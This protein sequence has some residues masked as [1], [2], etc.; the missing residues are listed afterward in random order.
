MQFGTAIIDPPWCYSNASKSPKLSGFANHEYPLLNEKGLTLLPVGELVTDTIFLWTTAP[1]VPQALR[2]IEAWGF[3]YITQLFW[4]KFSSAPDGRLI[5]QTP[6]G[7]NVDAFPHKPNY[8]VGYWVR[9]NTEPI[10]LAKKKKAPSVRTAERSSFM[11]EVPAQLK[12]FEGRVLITKAADHSEKPDNLHR[13]VEAEH[14]QG[15][16]K[17]RKFSGPYLELFARRQYPG[18]TCLGHELEG[19]QD[20]RLEMNRLLEM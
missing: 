10:I 14:H 11:T 3:E 12:P 7:A 9:G 19:Q 16:G 2:L 17:Y 15:E 1:M 18:W 20:I 8:G 13:L 6:T 4:Y 5:G